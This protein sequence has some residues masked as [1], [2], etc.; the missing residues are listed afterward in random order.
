VDDVNQDPLGFFSRVNQSRWTPVPRAVRRVPS[1]SSLFVSLV[2]HVSSQR[3]SHQGT[4]W[5]R[6]QNNNNNNN[7]EFVVNAKLDKETAEAKS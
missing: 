4:S 1:F 5:S 7:S 2:V 6:K 3:T